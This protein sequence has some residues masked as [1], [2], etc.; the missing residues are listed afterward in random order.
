MP[1]MNVGNRFIWEALKLYLPPGTRLTS[2]YRP[3]EAQLKFIV[4]KAR[5]H[6]YTFNEKPM[7]SKPATW[8]EALTFVRSKGYKVAAPGRS[9]H[10]QGLAY[11]LT[12]PNLQKIKAGVLRAV[13]EGRI[14]LVKNSRSRLLIERKNH[15]VHVEIESAVM[16]FDPFD[17]A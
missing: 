5:Q 17:W 2:V 11:D 12:G 15:C 8:Q 4:R 7:V 16:D 10:Q 14:R 3:P 1:K 13:K 9:M 6:G